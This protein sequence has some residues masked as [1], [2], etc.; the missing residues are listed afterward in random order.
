[1]TTGDRIDEFLRARSDR[2]PFREHEVKELLRG[3][4][5]SVPKGMFISRGTKILS[6]AG[7]SFPLVAKVVSSRIAS[8]SD[9]GGVRL[10]I[11]NGDE[12]Q[13]AV[14]ELSRMEHAE[15]VLVEEMARPGFEVIVGGIVDNSFGP[16]VMFGP[17]GLFVE[18]F[19]DVSFALAPVD[20]QQAI[21]LMK[22]TKGEK[23]LK[24]F[25]GQPPLD[26]CALTHVIVMVSEVIASGQFRTIDLNPVILYP[27]GTLVLDAKM[28]RI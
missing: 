26:V 11:G 28:S 21:W 19:R 4:G 12:L 6:V 18:L 24:G 27:S 13:K 16:I 2:D 10:G 5:L 1:M 8:K 15:G 14:S 7:L 23:I 17:G 25:R 9:I 20:R 22:E 3:L